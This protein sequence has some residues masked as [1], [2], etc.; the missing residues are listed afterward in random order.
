MNNLAS[1]L[2]SQGFGGLLKTWRTTRKLS[3]LDLSL[4]SNVS[5]R[6]LS[7]LES[8][9]SRPSQAMVMQLSEALDVPLRERNTLLQAAGF[10]PFFRQRNLDD[11]SMRPV[12]EALSRTLKH[13]HPFP[14]VVV[15]RAFNVVM[16]NDGFKTLVGLF[17]DPDSLW[18]ACCPSGVRN[19]FRLTF[20]AEGAR[21]LIRN[22][23]EIAPLMLQRAWRDTFAGDADL[24]SFIDELRHDP[25]LPAHWLVP[26][27]SAV[28][29]P[30]L[31][32]VLGRDKAEIKLFSM[33]S[34]FGTP[35][36][37]TTDE[38]RMETFF[39]ADDATE[40]LLRSLDET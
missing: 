13:H 25:S 35:Q 38:I 36:D 32:L 1:S 14:A 18:A 24:H 2:P 16:E 4:N 7:F 39:P 11:A 28:P 20:H 40:Q 3:Q 6:H 22:F 27:P 31:P 21:P 30:V 17:G 12:Y 33:I 5:Q 26:D 23:D 15:D 37:V 8:G 9:R 29:A 34:T 10:A 19:L